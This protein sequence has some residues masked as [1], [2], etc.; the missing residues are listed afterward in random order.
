M[1]VGGWK[2]EAGLKANNPPTA[3][4]CRGEAFADIKFECCLIF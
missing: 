2:V 3:C 1:E 4:S